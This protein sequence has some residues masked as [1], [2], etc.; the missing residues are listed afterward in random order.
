MEAPEDQHRGTGGGG[1][2]TSTPPHPSPSSSSSHAHQQHRPHSAPARPDIFM[3]NSRPHFLNFNQFQLRCWQWK[4]W[5]EIDSISDQIHSHANAQRCRGRSMQATPVRLG[6]PSRV[7]AERSATSKIQSSACAAPVSYVTSPPPHALSLRFSLFLSFLF[8][9]A[10]RTHVAIAES[11]EG[12]CG[13]CVCVNGCAF[14]GVQGNSFP[15]SQPVSLDRSNLRGIPPHFLR[16]LRRRHW[17]QRTTFTAFC[18]PH[19]PHLVCTQTEIAKAPK[20]Y[21]VAEKSDGTRFL[22]LIN[23]EGAY[24]VRGATTT[25]VV[26]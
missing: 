17:I 15:G 20:N 11:G 24:L 5:N 12:V 6:L 1:P 26:V 9:R 25:Y 7:G 14:V 13:V 2:P 4:G 19:L 22:M 3:G 8:L 23:K 16:S 18:S 10:T 21:W